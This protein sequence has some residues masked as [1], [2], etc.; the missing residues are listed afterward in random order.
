ADTIQTK[1][2][3]VLE[4]IFCSNFLIDGTGVKLK[5]VKSIADDVERLIRQGSRNLEIVDGV[6]NLPLSHALEVLEEFAQ[7][8]IRHPW[9]AMINPGAV[10]ERLVE[11]MAQT[12]CR[13]VQFGTD[14]GCDRV[15]STLKKN[16]RKRRL[17]EVQRLIESA[18]ITAMHCCFIGS[19]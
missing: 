6:F 5:D 17:R 1:K 12:G 16:F 13:E 7:R 10:N 3:C 4:C 8:G 18:G 14:S 15:L 11:L 2:G 9:S 19:P